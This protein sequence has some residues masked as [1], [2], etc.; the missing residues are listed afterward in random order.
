MLVN[1]RARLR[2][3]VLG[4]TGFLLLCGTGLLSAATTPVTYTGCLN[5]TTGIPY[6]VA[7]GSQSLHACLVS[8]PVER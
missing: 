4:A 1:P 3:A 5:K 6:N 2:L 8:R 7:V